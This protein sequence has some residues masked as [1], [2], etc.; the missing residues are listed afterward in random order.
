MALGEEIREL[1]KTKGLS[2]EAL[3][4]RLNISRQAVSKWENDLALPSAE[5]LRELSRLFEIPPERLT[6]TPPEKAA[7]TENTAVSE[8]ILHPN[9]IWKA[10]ALIASFTALLLTG[11]CLRLRADVSSSAAGDPVYEVLSE[12]VVGDDFSELPDGRTVCLQLV[13]E[14]GEY[15]TDKYENY[16][17]SVGMYA[18][19]YRGRY[20]LDV[21]LPSGERLSSRELCEDFD[22]EVLNFPGKVSLSLFDY[23]WDGCPEFTVGQQGSSSIMLYSLYTLESDG[24]LRKSCPVLIA[25][26]GGM[27]AFSV[28]LPRRAEDEGRGFCAYPYN[29]AIGEAVEEVYRW[30][31]AAGAFLPVQT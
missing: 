31:D 18:Q 8:K 24:S 15:F 26:S 4:E 10:I 27:D 20:R 13:L 7:F 19:N 28:V 23:N 2:Q 1:R 3:A 22:S 5:N 16:L 29:N 6:K 30:D 25:D 9:R 12:H 14:E 17:P 11:V 21:V